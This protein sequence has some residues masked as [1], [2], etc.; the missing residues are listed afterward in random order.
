MDNGDAAD[1][2]EAGGTWQSGQQAGYQDSRGWFADSTQRDTVSP[3]T[4]QFLLDLRAAQAPHLRFWQRL[5]LSGSDVAIVDISPDG[6]QTWQ[7][8]DQQPGHT[9][10]W[11]ERLIDLSAYRGQVIRLRFRLDTL[12]LVPDGENTVGW[13]IDELVAQDVTIGLPTTTPVPTAV[14]TEMPPPTELPTETLIPTA[15]PMPT[16]VPT[17]TPVPTY[18]P[19][20]LPT[21]AP[22]PPVEPIQDA[23]AV[24]PTE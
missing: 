4:A 8:L 18:T 11:G 15:T 17:T 9:A 20:A 13:W 6:G 10:E 2:W 16:E 19:T 12:G 21:D 22:E 1:N 3:L 7:P 24:P 23:V 14:P 5:G